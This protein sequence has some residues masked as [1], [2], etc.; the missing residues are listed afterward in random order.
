[1]LHCDCDFDCVFW[2]GCYLRLLQVV[3]LKSLCFKIS[4]RWYNTF[5]IFIKIKYHH[6][7]ISLLKTIDPRTSHPDKIGR[8]LVH[9]LKTREHSL[10]QKFRYNESL[11]VNIF[12]VHVY[13]NMYTLVSTDEEQAFGTYIEFL[14]RISSDRAATVPTTGG[15]IAQC[16]KMNKTESSNDSDE[17]KIKSFRLKQNLAFFLCHWACCQPQPTST[18]SSSRGADDVVIASSVMTCY[19]GYYGVNI[20][21][22]HWHI[23]C[24]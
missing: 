19:V 4:K 1:M 6:F 18:G 23:V 13:Y 12:Q 15:W 20:S 9:K 10:F 22:E 8:F 7:T 24:T 3:E 11:T 17:W 21:L 2:K 5:V 14:S 16:Q